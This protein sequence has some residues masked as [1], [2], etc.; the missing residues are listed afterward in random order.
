M[1]VTTRRRH[2]EFWNPS[3]SRARPI[4]ALLEKAVDDGDAS[5]VR[6]L[7]HKMPPIFTMLG[8][9]E[10]AGILRRRKAEN[11]GPD[12]RV[13]PGGAHGD[14]KNPRDCRGKRKKR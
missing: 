2:G 11:A 7:S 6:A 12:R 9:A 1:R 14:Q 3:Q 13:M 8:A 5:A 4:C 10:V